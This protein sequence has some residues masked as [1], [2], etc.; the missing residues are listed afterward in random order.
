MCKRLDDKRA[1]R[2]LLSDGVTGYAVFE[3]H[4]P[5]PRPIPHQWTSLQACKPEKLTLTTSFTVPVT[6]GTDSVVT[7]SLGGGLDTEA[8]WVG[9]VGVRWQG[10]MQG[11]RGIRRRKLQAAW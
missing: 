9:S 5:S 8:T 3:S 2:S 7:F 6:A 4:L 10:T 1:S 11:G